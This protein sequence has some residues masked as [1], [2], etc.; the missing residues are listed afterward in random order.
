MFL[1]Q[2]KKTREVL[3]PHPG[4]IEQLILLKNKLANKIQLLD[5]FKKTKKIKSINIA[6]QKTQTSENLVKYIIGIFLSNTNI[7]VYITDIKGKVNLFLSAGSLGLNG[8]QKTKKPVV[9]IK[10]MRLALSKIKFTKNTYV[11]LNL[12]NFTKFNISLILSLLKK[13]LTIELVRVYNN[14]PYNGCRPKKLKR[15]KRRRLV[16]R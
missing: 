3:K 1:L 13:Y 12:K 16:F 14:K 8:K 10:M 4:N 2:V 11:A 7:N 5:F 6:L 9:L 15:K